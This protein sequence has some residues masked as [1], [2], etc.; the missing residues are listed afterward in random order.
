MF[1]CLAVA[2]PV[3][4]ERNERQEEESRHEGSMKKFWF[5]RINRYHFEFRSDIVINEN[6]CL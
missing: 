4:D 1:V 5:G 3:R 2:D 6:K